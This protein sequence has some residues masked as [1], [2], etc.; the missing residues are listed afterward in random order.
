MRPSPFP[1][2]NPWLEDPRLWPGLHDSLLTYF[3]DE[4]QL[5]LPDAYF[6]DLQDRVY[7]ELAGTWIV[8]DVRIS[9]R[10]GAAPGALRAAASGASPAL[11]VA[12]PDVEVREPY[13]VIRDARKDER[14]VA[15]VELLSPA[16]K[17]GGEGARRYLE[18]QQ[19]LLASEVH[20]I[21]IDLL[22]GGEHVVAVPAASVP[23]GTRYLVCVRRGDRP[24]HRELYPC[25]LADPLPRIAVPL[26]APDP[27]LVVDLQAL[28]AKAW[29]GGAY[30]K[31]IDY[32]Q[33]PVPPLEP[34]D[35]DQAARVL[36]G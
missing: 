8:P 27:D 13:V 23:E 11:M 1:G 28:L 5:H 18:K 4:L 32:G 7:L 17:R 29:E 15:V 34:A 10:D 31:R 24:R 21:E 22:R 35:A 14:V 33:P 30:W 12:V 2:M 26:R 16:N 9:Q 36:A 25:T 6:A 20:L 3:R 19:E